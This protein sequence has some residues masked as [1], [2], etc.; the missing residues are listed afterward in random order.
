M[1]IESVMPSSHLILCHPFLLLPPLAPRHIHKDG[2]TNNE[3]QLRLSM[4]A[5]H[6]IES[7]QSWFFF[8]HAVNV[9]LYM[10]FF[11]LLIFLCGRMAVLWTFGW[12]EGHIHNGILFSHKNEQN[13]AICG[14]VDGP[15]DHQTQ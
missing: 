11:F 12:R 7:P 5:L 4:A 10:L 2:I 14:K 9:L 8:L 13:N 6:L 1:P 3:D 15:R